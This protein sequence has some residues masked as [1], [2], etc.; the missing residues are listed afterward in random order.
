MQSVQHQTRIARGVSESLALWLVD[1]GQSVLRFSAEEIA[2][3][4]G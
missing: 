1:F 3:S 4:D 2:Q